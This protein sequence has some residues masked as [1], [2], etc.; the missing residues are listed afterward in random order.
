MKAGALVAEINKRQIGFTGYALD[1]PESI[2][3]K[4]LASL[5]HPPV[6]GTVV[7]EGG[8]DNC[9]C[10]IIILGVGDLGPGRGDCGQDGKQQCASPD[11]GD[12]CQLD[13]HARCFHFS[14]R[15][16]FLQSA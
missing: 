9:Y 3:C 11:Q 15:Q 2:L 16:T 8:E 14:Y 5:Y 7:D 10:R 4:E 1:I 6:A 13:S 12:D